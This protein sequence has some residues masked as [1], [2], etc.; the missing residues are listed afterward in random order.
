VAVNDR[1]SNQTE[2]A[3]RL[4][5]ADGNMGDWEDYAIRIEAL[6]KRTGL[7]PEQIEKVLAELSMWEVTSL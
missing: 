7:L 4:A 1:D 3:R 5:E 6:V 2:A